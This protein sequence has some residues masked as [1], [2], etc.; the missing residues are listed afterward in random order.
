[1]RHI[2][3]DG[4][5]Q[6]YLGVY[7]ALSHFQTV[8]TFIRVPVCVCVSHNSHIMLRHVC[9]SAFASTCAGE[10]DPPSP[11]HPATRPQCGIIFNNWSAN[12][13]AIVPARVVRM[14]AK[15]CPSVLLRYGRAHVCWQT[16]IDNNWISLPLVGWGTH[17]WSA[18]GRH[19]LSCSRHVPDYFLLTMCLY[20]IVSCHCFV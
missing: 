16:R 19:A 3:I 20:C 11:T 2:C 1:M 13:F 5:V 8:A 12:P 6:I 4:I 10:Q 17:Q 7:Y 15:E 9:A 14:D 18:C